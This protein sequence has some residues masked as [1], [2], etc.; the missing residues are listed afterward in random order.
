MSLSFSDLRQPVSVTAAASLA[1]RPTQA[2][3]SRGITGSATLE[4]LIEAAVL[5]ALAAMAIRLVYRITG[6]AAGM[7]AWVGGAIAGACLYAYCRCGLGL[8][9]LVSCCAMLMAIFHPLAVGTRTTTTDLISVQP[10]LILGLGLC[11]AGLMRAPSTVPGIVAAAFALGFLGRQDGVAAVLLIGCALLGG[12]GQQPTLP[13]AWRTMSGGRWLRYVAVCIALVISGGLAATWTG[14][15]VP[16]SQLP[17]ENPG[18]LAWFD[19]D[20][21]LA[22]NTA[23]L[24]P[25]YSAGDGRWYVGWSVI[26]LAL[27]ALWPGSDPTTRRTVGA[28]LVVAVTVLWFLRGPNTLHD[29][30]HGLFQFVTLRREVPAVQQHMIGLALLMFPVLGLALF[31]AIQAAFRRQARSLPAMLCSAAILLLAWGV[32]PPMWP[33]QTWSVSGLIGGSNVC[34]ALPAF[35]LAITAALGLKRLSGRAP[36]AAPRLALAAAMLALLVWDIS[37][38]LVMRP[39]GE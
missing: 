14:P 13:A 27:A 26:G 21:L 34:G 10:A 30:V 5:L 11:A 38:Y 33:S 9:R 25:E 8:G 24:P 18:P 36:R 35:G 28:H 12:V 39:L 31:W 4:A 23:V 17:S 7:G 2:R 3:R 16:A 22:K 37:P 19:R 15:V 29:Q 1:D 32:S 6:S 20:G